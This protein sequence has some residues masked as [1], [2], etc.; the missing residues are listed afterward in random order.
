M[1]FLRPKKEIQNEK[2]K[3]WYKTLKNLGE[4]V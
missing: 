3:E 1:F 2:F 4:F